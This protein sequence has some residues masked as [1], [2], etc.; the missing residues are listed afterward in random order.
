MF[1]PQRSSSAQ[2]AQLMKTFEMDTYCIGYIPARKDTRPIISHGEACW[3][4][5][6]R[7]LRAKCK[8]LSRLHSTLAS[9]RDIMGRMHSNVHRCV[10]IPL[11]RS[12]LGAN[13]LLYFAD[14]C[15]GPGGFTEYMLYR[16][17]WHAKGYGFTLRSEHF[18][19]AFT[20]LH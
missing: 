5:A 17:K 14:I 3:S 1:R 20:V 11:Q 8:A 19:S 13:E 12:V 6:K 2:L 18:L 4:E 15:A 9:Q 10:Y 7:V 16:T